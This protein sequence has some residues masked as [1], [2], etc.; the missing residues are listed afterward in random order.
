[1]VT[2]TF[3]RIGRVML[4]AGAGALLLTLLAAVLLDG[5]AGFVA[6]LVLGIITVIAV[7]QGVLWTVLQHRMFGSPARLREVAASG[8]SAAAMIVAVRSTSSSIGAEPIARLDLRIDGEVVRRH[9]RVPFN[10][11]AE[12]RVGRTLPVRVH[13]NDHWAMIVDWEQLG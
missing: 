9:V 13:P 4:L 8:R 10:Y 2:V 7:V 3:G 12:C 1:M 5:T 6:T 11:A